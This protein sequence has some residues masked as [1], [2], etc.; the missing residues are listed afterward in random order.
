MATPLNYPYGL[1]ERQANL[2]SPPAVR[3]QLPPF[4]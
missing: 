1:A 3:E 2:I 4:G